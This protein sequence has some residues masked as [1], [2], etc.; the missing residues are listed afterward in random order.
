MMMSQP[1][2]PSC[3]GVYQDNTEFYDCGQSD[4]IKATRYGTLDNLC[5]DSSAEKGD[6]ASQTACQAH[7][8]GGGTSLVFTDQ[9]GHDMP[10]S[11]CCATEYKQMQSSG[12]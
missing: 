8:V 5:K 1:I 3:V 2:A 7:F 9:G 6:A 12:Y 11:A 10:T 4:F